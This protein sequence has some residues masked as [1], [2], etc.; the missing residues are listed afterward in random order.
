MVVVVV[1]FDACFSSS[2]WL[3][4]GCGRFGLVGIWCLLGLNPLVEEEKRKVCCGFRVLLMLMPLPVW[5]K[6]L[7]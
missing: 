6:D 7:A 1:G 4:L 2:F 3:G 5:L